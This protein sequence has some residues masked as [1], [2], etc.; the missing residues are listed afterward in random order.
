MTSLTFTVTNA[1]VA[2]LETANANGNVFVAD[3][4]CGAGVTGCA[5][6]T[7]PVDAHTRNG[8]PDGGVTLMLLG[9]ALVGLETLRRK[10]SV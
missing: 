8:I 3:I 6:Q 9:S 5:G 7:G 10:F 4:L 1:T 2:Q